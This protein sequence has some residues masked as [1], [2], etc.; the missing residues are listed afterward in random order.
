MGQVGGAWG[1]VAIKHQLHAPLLLVPNLFYS[2]FVFA[3][4]IGLLMIA[5]VM[6]LFVRRRRL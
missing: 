6:I 4:A 1:Q 2:R 3:L 5:H